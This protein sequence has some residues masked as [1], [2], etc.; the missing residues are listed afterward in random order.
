[1]TISPP[2]VRAAREALEAAIAA[3]R[4]EGYSPL[5]DPEHP[6]YN[7]G[8]V[9]DGPHNDWGIVWEDDEPEDEAG[10]GEDSEEE[11]PR[12]RTVKDEGWE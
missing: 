2:R 9:E 1:M 4:E 3:D 6:M 10:A 11:N 5:C 12:W 7:A 8:H